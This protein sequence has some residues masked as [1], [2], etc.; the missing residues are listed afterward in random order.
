M[1]RKETR[2]EKIERQLQERQQQEAIGAAPQSHAERRKAK[3]R[4]G[5]TAEPVP[6]DP[7]TFLDKMRGS[8]A[9][10]MP[11]ALGEVPENLEMTISAGQITLPFPW[12]RYTNRL[13]SVVGLDVPSGP[14]IMVRLPTVVQLTQTA[15][16]M[17]SR[18][19]AEA[20]PF[21]EG[22][23]TSPRSADP[24]AW[25]TGQ[26][27]APRKSASFARTNASP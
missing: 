15:A 12:Q 4:S 7:E 2:K 22:W 1:G 14:R 21:S 13:G 8:M 11:A 9:N 26:R 10:H 23:R 6:V 5:G 25:R 17:H 20:G 18:L 3:H 19:A 16:L 24:S 27:N